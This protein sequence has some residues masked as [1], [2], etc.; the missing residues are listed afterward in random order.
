[1]ELYA[2]VLALSAGGVGVTALAGAASTAEVITGLV[3]LAVGLGLG[4]GASWFAWTHSPGLL[5]EA[6]ERNDPLGRVGARGVRFGSGPTVTT[7]PLPNKVKWTTDESAKLPELIRLG[8]ELQ[9]RT[10]PPFDPNP[11]PPGRGRRP[12]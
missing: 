4:A 10:G 7:T 12:G 8:T 6:R 9:E 2:G 1:M 11:R 5:E 3:F